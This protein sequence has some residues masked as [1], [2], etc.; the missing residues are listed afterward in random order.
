MRRKEN[1]RKAKKDIKR[2][3]QNLESLMLFQIVNIV[4]APEKEAEVEVI[5]RRNR[6]EVVILGK[7]TN[8][9]QTHTRKEKE[10]MR[11]EEI[12]VEAIARKKI[13]LKLRMTNLKIT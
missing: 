6:K 5:L 2:K 7:E 10:V 12:I 3:G 4:E 8:I 1:K 13:K 9:N 11:K